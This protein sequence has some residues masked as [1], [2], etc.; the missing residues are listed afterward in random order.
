MLGYVVGGRKLF[1]VADAR[2]RWKDVGAT[3]TSML[4]FFHC[5]VCLTKAFLGRHHGHAGH[6]N[7]KSQGP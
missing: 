7:R 5:R 4:P 2:Q 6:A 1:I 3:A